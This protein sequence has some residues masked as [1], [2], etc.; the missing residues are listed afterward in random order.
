MMFRNWNY[1]LNANVEWLDWRSLLHRLFVYFSLKIRE[2][3]ESDFYLL[4][5]A[6]LV[7]ACLFVSVGEMAFAIS[8]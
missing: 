2:G 6:H 3:N 4:I 7:F 8:L 5:A 1:R